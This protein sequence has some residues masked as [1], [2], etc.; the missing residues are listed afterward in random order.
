MPT[1]CSFE[2]FIHQSFHF[3][4]SLDVNWFEEGVSPLQPW[5]VLLPVETSGIMHAHGMEIRGGVVTD[6]FHE[7]HLRTH[8]TC[9]LMCIHTRLK[10]GSPPWHTTL[11]V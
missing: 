6:R 1:E 8:P 10:Y 4:L 9:R 11:H 7:I 5:A 3:E 2:Q